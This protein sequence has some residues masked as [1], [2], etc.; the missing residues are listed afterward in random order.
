MILALERQEEERQLESKREG[1]ADGADRK[2][3]ISGHI[4]LVCV[5]AIMQISLLSIRRTV[6]V[7]RVHLQMTPKYKMH[8]GK[9]LR[10]FYVV[11]RRME[12]H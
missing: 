2:A 4:R 9:G 8:V 1:T 7:K 10:N 12:L 5:Q 6:E 11:I 3:Q